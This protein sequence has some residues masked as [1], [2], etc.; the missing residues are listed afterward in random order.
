MHGWSSQDEAPEQK[1][2]QACCVH[3]QEEPE[4]SILVHVSISVET[5]ACIEAGLTRQLDVQLT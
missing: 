5:Q 3:Q 1:E 2:P 4:S